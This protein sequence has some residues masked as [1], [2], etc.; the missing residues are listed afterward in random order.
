MGTKVKVID[1]KYCLE[2]F[3]LGI[4]Y[5]GIYAVV[6]EVGNF[7]HIGPCDDGSYR[8]ILKKR[9]EIVQS[10]NTENPSYY[11]LRAK[12]I[13]HS[14]DMTHG[15]I[16]NV[17]PCKGHEKY[18]YELI[19]DAGDENH[20]HK[21]EFEV[22]EEP[23]ETLEEGTPEVTNPS[24]YTR[25]TIQPIVFIREN[26]LSFWQG[27]VIKYVCREDAKGGLEDLKKARE[28]LDNEIK[29]REG[30]KEWWK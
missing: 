22:L 4:H 17:A 29:R 16:Y 8:D 21:I 20:R 2:G 19:D 6:R 30:L 9:C 1:E 13:G 25:F 10:D 3:A 12:Y 5:L 23:Q 26:N 28:Y 24:Y 11:T 15:K 18:Y 7:W 27:N 14:T